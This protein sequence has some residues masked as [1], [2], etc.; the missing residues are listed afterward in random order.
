MNIFLKVSFLVLGVGASLPAAGQDLY[1]VFATDSATVDSIFRSQGLKE[2]CQIVSENSQKIIQSSELVFMNEKKQRLIGE[3]IQ[4][5]VFTQ[6]YPKNEPPY[7]SRVFY[8]FGFDT[9]EEAR[10][11]AH[12]QRGRRLHWSL[13]TSRNF[14]HRLAIAYKTA[15]FIRTINYQWIPSSH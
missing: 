13:P 2:A 15:I 4:T 12:A 6:I 8:Q 1:A 9:V 10:R 5:A 14:H 7:L 11:R 3:A